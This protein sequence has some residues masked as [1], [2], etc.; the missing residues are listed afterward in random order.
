MRE[1]PFFGSSL[2]A[3]EGGAKLKEENIP[4]RDTVGPAIDDLNRDENHHFL[5]TLKLW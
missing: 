5:G 3:G 1:E 4:G 2:I